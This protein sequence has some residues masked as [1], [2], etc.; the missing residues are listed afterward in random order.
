MLGDAIQDEGGRYVQAHHNMAYSIASDTLGE[1]TSE[2][3]QFAA[4][5]SLFLHSPFHF[6]PEYTTL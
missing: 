6:S 1:Q 4:S 2:L 5:I 3:T